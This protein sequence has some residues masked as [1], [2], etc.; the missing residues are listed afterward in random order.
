M[1]VI[2]ST[3]F[4]HIDVTEISVSASKKVL[5]TIEIRHLVFFLFIAALCEIDSRRYLV[6]LWLRE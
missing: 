5:T 4:L 3:F 6:W 1:F 2:H